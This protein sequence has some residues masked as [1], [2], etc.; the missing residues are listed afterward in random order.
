MLGMNNLDLV[1]F[2]IIYY[3]KNYL[4]ILVIGVVG[5]TPLIKSVLN[6]IDNSKNKFVAIIEMVIYIGLLIVCSSALISNSF[7]PFI[8]F[9]F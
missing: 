4:I 9:R 8:Y 1:N 3:L 5:A 2:E 6:K 7:N